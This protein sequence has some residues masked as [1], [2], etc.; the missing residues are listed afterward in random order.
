MKKGSNFNI[1][2]SIQQWVFW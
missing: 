2:I 1:L